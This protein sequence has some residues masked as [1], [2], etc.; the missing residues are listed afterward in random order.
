[1]DEKEK[2]GHGD[3]GPT[4]ANHHSP[5]LNC[6]WSQGDAWGLRREALGSDLGLLASMMTSNLKCRVLAPTEHHVYRGVP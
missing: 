1:M 3:S 5:R 4:Q 6:C 2:S